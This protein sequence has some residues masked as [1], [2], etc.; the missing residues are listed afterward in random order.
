MKKRKNVTM[1]DVQRWIAQGLGQGEG[2]LY[3]PF[4]YVR[5]VPSRGRSRMVLGLKTGRVHHYLSDLEYACH[6][7]AEYEPSVA[8]IREQF[9]LLEWEETQEI[10]DR[11]GIRHPIYPG[12]ATPTVM[13]SD[14]VLSLVKEKRPSVAVVCVKPFSQVDPVNPKNSRTREKLF[15]EKVYWEK[16]GIPWQL[17]TEK[18]IPL[19]RAQNLDRLRVH[20]VAAEL[21][22]LDDHMESFLEEFN[23]SWGND[24]SFL[25]ILSRVAGRTGLSK[26]E[27]SYLF[28]RA[29]WLR[30]LDVDLDARVIH[31]DMPV[32]RAQRREA[33]FV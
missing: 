28:G 32:P 7:L 6:L 9:A 21:N 12:T 15:I 31:H 4:F 26:D 27:C 25:T 23:S 11:F 29:V 33:H 24:S 18:E 30:L 5:D 17:L 10:A 19:V 8:G 2:S 13:T 3:R 20:M 1:Q 14:L 22:W 16:R